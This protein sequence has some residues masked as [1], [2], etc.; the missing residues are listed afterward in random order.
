MLF[1]VREDARI[2]A[3]WNHSFGMHLSS[4]GQYSVFSYPEFPQGSPMGHLL[5]DGLMASASFVYWYGR[6]H[7]NSHDNHFSNSNLRF[8]GY[9]QLFSCLLI[10]LVTFSCICTF[11]WIGFNFLHGFEINIVYTLYELEMFSLFSFFRGIYIRLKSFCYQI[12]VHS[13]HCTI[14]QLIW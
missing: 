14:G 4:L 3:H 9:I 11:K 8:S 5:C 12:Q 10:F 6:W 13:V 2:W 1:Y 7:F